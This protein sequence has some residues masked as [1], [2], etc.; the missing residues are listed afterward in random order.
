MHWK[1]FARAKT[2]K[3]QRKS[4]SDPHLK[5]RAIAIIPRG[6]RMDA[7]LVFQLNFPYALQR[8]AQN[9]S[10]EFELPLIGNVL[11]VATSAL[12]EISA[13]RLNTSLDASTICETVPRAKPGLPSAFRLRP[14]RRQHKRHENRH[15]AAVRPGWH[16]RQSISAVDQFF[17]GKKHFRFVWRG[18][19][20]PR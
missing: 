9:L 6:G 13:A 17:N 12:L 1:K 8:L 3:A 20:C 19:S 5:P 16:A 4:G 14:V 15:A 18:H 2:I 10:L 7:N 11:V